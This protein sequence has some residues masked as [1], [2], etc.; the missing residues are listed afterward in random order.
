MLMNAANGVQSIPRQISVKSRSVSE[1]LGHNV[2]SNIEGLHFGFYGIGY[3]LT[4]PLQGE[5]EIKL[6]DVSVVR[7]WSWQCLCQF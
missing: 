3:Y 2:D 7:F 1:G 6:V 4:D 5:L